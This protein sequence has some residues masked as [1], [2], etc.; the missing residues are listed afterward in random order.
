MTRHVSDLPAEARLALALRA[1]LAYRLSI[2]PAQEP[3]CWAARRACGG[4]PAA[5]ASDPC[6]ATYVAD[7]TLAWL[8]LRVFPTHAIATGLPPAP[9]SVLVHHFILFLC[10]DS[11][12]YSAFDSINVARIA[13]KTVGVAF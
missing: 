10:V 9:T 12:S 1:V 11:R 4:F 5:S 6:P 8:D 7:W 2:G 13:S 3:E